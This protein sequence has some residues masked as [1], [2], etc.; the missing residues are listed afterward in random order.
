MPDICKIVE[1]ILTLRKSR[2]EG[3]SRDCRYR[4]RH[5]RQPSRMARTMG[6]AD[7]HMILSR[8]FGQSALLLSQR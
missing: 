6:R 3:G 5:L 1:V 7:G 4:H 8:M 2:P